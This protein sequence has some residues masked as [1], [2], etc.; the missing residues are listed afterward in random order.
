MAA[1]ASIAMVS[2]VSWTEAGLRQLPACYEDFHCC[3]I[4]VRSKKLGAFDLEL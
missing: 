1:A 3:A 2:K 4:P